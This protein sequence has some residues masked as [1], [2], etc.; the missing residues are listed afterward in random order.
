MWTVIFNR[1]THSCVVIDVLADVWVEEVIK[2]LIAVLV[3]KVSTEVVIE[4][5]GV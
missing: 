2:V 5:S 4:M 3:M 1:L